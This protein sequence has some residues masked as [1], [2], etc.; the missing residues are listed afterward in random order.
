MVP[1]FG[2]IFVALGAPAAPTL[3]DLDVAALGRLAPELLVCDIDQQDV[4]RLEL[5]RQLRFVLPNCIIAAYTGVTQRVWARKCHLAGANC[6]LAKGSSN[7]RLTNGLREA[8]SSGCYTDP[9]F[10]A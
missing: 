3:V 9:A 1:V 10:A 8:F 5:L 4:D 2:A 6:L 7:E